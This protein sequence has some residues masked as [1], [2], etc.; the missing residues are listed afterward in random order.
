MSASISKPLKFAQLLRLPA[1]AAKEA[2]SSTA[3]AT[4]VPI[5]L[6]EPVLDDDSAPMVADEMPSPTNWAASAG[7]W[8]WRLRTS[9]F[10]GTISAIVH[11]VLIVVLAVVASRTAETRRS[12]VRRL[13]ADMSNRAEKQ[14]ILPK[15]LPQIRPHTES[16]VNSQSPNNSSAR[17]NGSAGSGGGRGGGS[18]GGLA[19]AGGMPGKFNVASGG[20]GFGTDDAFGTHM[21]GEIGEQGDPTASFFGVKAGGNKFVFVVDSSGSMEHNNRF[22][23]CLNE[24]QRSLTSLTYGQQYLVIFFSSS[25][26][27]MPENRLVDARPEQ[28][29]RTLQWIGNHGYGGGTEPWPAL[30]RAIINKPDAIFFL[31]DGVFND[32]VVLQVDKIQPETKKKIPIHTIAF[33]DPI[34][35]KLLKQIADQSGGEFKYVP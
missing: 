32:D 19:S 7:L 8:F 31:T 13:E 1:N 6:A 27:A 12:P 10:S 9:F 4:F 34:G 20:T 28:L 21:L 14:E 17:G 25:M 22:L 11:G 24:L 15:F 3:A 30:K 5:A 29:K 23:R 18:I 35:A 26:D 2:P 16:P 33:E